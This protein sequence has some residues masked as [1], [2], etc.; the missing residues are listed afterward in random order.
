MTVNRPLAGSARSSG[1][2][3]RPI[4]SRLGWLRRKLLAWVF[5][6]GAAWLFWLA[7]VVFAF[8]FGLDWL[9]RMDMAQRGVMLVLMIAAVGTMVFWRLVAPLRRVPTDDALIL[10]VEQKHKELGESLISGAQFSR[11]GDD[12]TKQ[13]VSMEMVHATIDAGTKA[14][15]RV[16]FG[17]TLN[18]S[19]FFVNLFLALVAMIGVGAGVA[20]AAMNL[21]DMGLLARRNLLLSDEDW[22]RDIHIAIINP[23]WLGRPIAH[24]ETWIQYVGIEKDSK[25][26]P[27]LVYVDRFGESSSTQQSHT[28][29]LIESKDPEY[30]QFKESF[31][32]YAQVYKVTV[33]GIDIEGDF[34]YQGR[35]IEPSEG[36]TFRNTEVTTDLYNVHVVEQPVMVKLAI[37]MTLPKYAGGTTHTIQ[38]G[39]S[40]YFVKGSSLRL[41]G[42]SNKS[43]VRAKLQY[44]EQSYATSDDEGESSGP[45]SWP[46]EVS[47]SNRVTGFVPGADVRHGKYQIVLKDTDQVESNNPTTFTINI[48]PD[49]VPKVR[50]EL[51]G[52]SGMVIP[53]AMIPT[54]VK[55]KDDFAITKIDLA[56]RYRG[57]GQ[58]AALG[59]GEIPFG[60]PQELMEQSSFASISMMSSWLI[61]GVAHPALAIAGSSQQ[62]GAGAQRQFAF[63]GFDYY[64]IFDL[65]PLGIPPGV[66]LTFEIKAEDND[67]LSGPNQG[68]STEFLVL[69]VS[70][71]RLRTD[72]LRRE[73]EQRQEFERLIKEQEDL[74]VE[75][76]ALAAETRAGG[77][78]D[79][80]QRVL[81]RDGQRKQKV[82][83]TNIAE[84][85]ERLEM[86]LIE[87]ENNRLEAEG[88][89]FHRRL[90]TG[91]IL[92]MYALVER[93]RPSEDEEAEELPN[94][95]SVE[96][97]LH[98]VRQFDMQESFE[99]RT[100]R[101][102]EVV[103]EQEMILNI[104]RD[105]RDQM[106][107][108]ESFQEAVQLLHELELLQKG[109]LDLTLDELD[110][111]LKRLFDEGGKAK[112]NSPSEPNNP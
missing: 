15:E 56:Y 79:K 26:M 63:D 109:V 93:P 105:I 108:S 98:S 47:D 46:L 61:Q 102:D 76:K 49:R 83:G 94:I 30:L 25:K 96:D 70:E 48:R 89:K 53:K 10:E 55:I 112:P 24:G 73:K 103:A 97:G 38:P 57:D 52:I 92:P 44:V 74:H 68:S 29:Q 40:P 64:D 1:S 20:C 13:G 69:V 33:R 18:K 8:D 50:A 77:V 66:T 32:E 31:D 36:F 62:F 7:L 101:L 37:E 45:P 51:H 86:L 100:Q 110:E 84:I 14:A 12:V 43:L 82:I 28:A 5:V 80:K 71:E 11:L 59:K 34:Q 41:E 42:T 111:L 16:S 6:D 17:D 78:Y 65:E 88:S 91:V 35:A 39:Q 106:V 27:E 95:P 67:T 87:A 81:L 3:P 85:S 19:K 60:G 104:M 9:F 21:G 22:P 99:A 2:I 54:T 72:L 4:A 90:A 75:L 107:K 23:D 58:D